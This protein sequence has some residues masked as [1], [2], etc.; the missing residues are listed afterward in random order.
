MKRSL[1]CLFLGFCAFSGGTVATLLTGRLLAPLPVHAQTPTPGGQPAA[2]TDVLRIGARGPTLLEDFVLRRTAIGLFG[3]AAPD[4][5][6][7]ISRQMAGELNWTEEHRLR[8][9]AALTSRY[10]TREAA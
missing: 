7:P 9:I 4:V 10:Q 8:E 3:P 6:D 2:G 5:L 1:L